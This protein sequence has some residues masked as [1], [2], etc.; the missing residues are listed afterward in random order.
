M[1]YDFK[2]EFNAL[3]REESPDETRVS[4]AQ[5]D[6]EV[7]KA[8]AEEIVLNDQIASRERLIYLRET[9]D[10]LDTRLT[11]GELRQALWAARRSL[12]GAAEPIGQ[13]DKLDL[14]EAPW[15][16][17]DVIL[18]GTSNLVVALPKVGK[19]RLMCQ[20]LARM[21]R[22]DGSFLGKELLAEHRPILVVG[23]D[24]PKR[25][26]AKCFSLAGLLNA[27]NT[28]HESIVALFHKGCPLHLDEEGIDRIVSYC[29]K[30]SGLV[31]LLDSY[32]ACINH[33]GL[34][35]SKAMFAEPL[36]DLQ[37]AIAPH[38]CTLVVIHHSSK[39]KAGQ[40]A[41]M[42]S[43]GGTALPAAVSQTI[44][45]SWAQGGELVPVRDKR[46][47]LATEGRESEPIEIW[48][49]QI[50][51]G[52]EWML[53]GSAGELALRQ[54]IEQAIENLTERQSDAL[55]VFVSHWQKHQAGIDSGALAKAL[56]ITGATPARKAREVIMRLLKQ[57]LIEPDGERAAQGD[58]GGQPAKLFRPTPLVLTLSENL[59][60]LPLEPPLESVEPLSGQTKPKRGTSGK[61]ASEEET[62]QRCQ[63]CSTEFQQNS[64]GRK[65]KFCSD[66]CRKQSNHQRSRAG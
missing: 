57:G 44:D 25:D 58:L 35:E 48:I 7:I 32:A 27:D 46:V 16:W 33:L 9:A 62:T 50:K 52:R 41:S 1:T 11:D 17:Q 65:K 15:L 60:L 36:L 47:K 51:E 38:D 12:N 30:H 66:A 49:E 63:Q 39:G 4:N 21:V 61:R 14:S 42:A 2:D 8:R 19:S 37:E 56:M 43:R 26:W 55:A 45:L 24:Q 64:R 59:P 40:R 10:G 22:G 29:E 13:G 31:I 6:L 3:A 18:L 54:Q 28:M 20:V 23:T 34:D 53:H 5:A